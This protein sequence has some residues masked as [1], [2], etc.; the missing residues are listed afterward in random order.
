MFFP[1]SY[2]VYVSV[3]FDDASMVP[4]I[5]LHPDPVCCQTIYLAVAVFCKN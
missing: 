3:L 1:S 4:A 5:K 2:L